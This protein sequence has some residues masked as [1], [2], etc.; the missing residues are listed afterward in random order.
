VTPSTGAGAVIGVVSS[1]QIAS[2]TPEVMV[3]GQSYNLSQIIGV[4]ATPT[5]PTP[6]T[7][8]PTTTSPNNPASKTTNTNTNQT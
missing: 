3:N 2:G 4:T 1:V 5:T 7:P 8:A 6:T